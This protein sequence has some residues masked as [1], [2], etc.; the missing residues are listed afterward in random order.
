MGE[1]REGIVFDSPSGKVTLSDL[2]DGR[3]RDA[4]I[5]KWVKMK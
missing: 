5:R 2:F 3:G 4:P 1:S